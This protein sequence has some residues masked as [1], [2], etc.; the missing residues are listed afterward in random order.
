MALKLNRRTVLRGIGGAVVGLPAL[1]CMLDSHGEALA[2]SALPRRYAL[3]FA[4]Q[5][6][7]GDNWPKNQFRLN[8]TRTTE[9]GHFIAPPEVGTNYTLT[10]PLQPLA[11][12]RGDYSL[13][14]NL[15]IPFSRTSAEP[16][17]VPM[18]GAFR[19]FHGGGKSPLLSGT[20]SQAENFTCNGITSD[21]VVAALHRGQTAIDSLVYRAQPSW[22]LS[23]S[24]YSGR[25]Y[26]SYSGPRQPI[27]AQASPQI[28]Y[29]ALFDN[30][31]PTGARDQ[32]IFD[33]R[34]RSRLSVLDL[35]TGKR[36]RLV[37]QLSRSDQVRLE[38]H[39]D[40][41]RALE[42]RINALPP[43]GGG[44]CQVLPD[45]GADPA[46]GGD[47]SGQTSS[48]IGTN[49][50]YSGEAERARVLADLIH[51]AFVCDRTRVATLQITTFQSHMN[52]FVPSSD[53]GLPL[54]ADLHEVGHNGDAQNAGQLPVSTMLRW[55]IS[56]YA[57][58]VDKLKQTPEGAGNLLDNCAV[59]FLPEG[60]HG[61]Q[62]N[63]AVSENQTHSVENMVAIIAGR[64][65]GLNP[66]RHID[67][68]GRHPVE[69]LI[70]AMRAAG[71]TGD[72][73]G[74]VTGHISELFV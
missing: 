38:Q 45:P 18:G 65:G 11:Q 1:E 13:V 52:V 67:S 41:I 49:T 12:L 43:V 36:Q 21:Q 63:D 51:M 26:V 42:D 69:A 55:H 19:G 64:A 68:G 54:R 62:L 15:R 32:A 22:Y 74:E 72:S 50:G 70:S 59:V 31:T 25:Q 5:S 35:I 16:S 39:F 27:A 61:L 34:K 8:G 24:S 20:R 17:E 56:H 9:D 47:N 10:T 48:D 4:G 33:F 6:I 66:G 71:Y 2:Q 44:E 3:V 37:S 60:G 73:L 58:L 46:I 30:F 40:E 57:Y 53:L 28:A 7:G 23:G 14:S 29:Q